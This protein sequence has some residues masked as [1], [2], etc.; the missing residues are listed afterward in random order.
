MPEVAHRPALPGNL[1]GEP[2]DAWQRFADDPRVFRLALAAT[3]LLPVALL[4]TR[5]T[6]DA[7]LSLVAILFL[8]RACVL[9]DWSW[10]H[11]AHA[12]LAVCFWLWLVVC[13]FVMGTHR[14]CGEALVVCRLL[15]FAAALENWVL[16]RQSQ[17]RQLW[18]VILAVAAWIV[19][20]T[21]EQYA[22]GSNIFGYRRWGSGVLTGPF[23]RTAG[24]RHATGC[25]ISPPSCHRQCT[26]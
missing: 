13:T 9:R 22:L 21:W 24:R 23:W 12:R 2:V 20:E 16:A 1:R 11:T 19:I 5:A 10:L 25:S 14:A 4:Y 3:L 6:G 26:G 17:C 18:L 7:L 8:A 15:L